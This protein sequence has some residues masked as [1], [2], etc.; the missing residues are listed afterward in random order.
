MWFGTE[1][2]VS[3][4]DSRGVT[5]GDFPHFVNFTTK[6]GLVHNWVYAIHRDPDGV[7]WFGTWGGGVS[8]YDGKGFINFTTK[9]GLANNFVNNIYRDPDGVMWFGTGSFF[10]EEKGGVSRYDERTFVGFTTM[11]GLASNSVLATYSDSDGVIWF[12]TGNGISHY[13]G[14]A[15]VD[16][17]V[18]DEVEDKTIRDMYRDPDG[19]MW[20]ATYG[21]GAF[22]YDG[23]KSAN[24]TTEDGLASNHI[25]DI[26]RDPDGVMWFGTSSGVSRYD[27]EQFVNLTTKDGLAHDHVYAIHGDLDG[28]I[29]FATDGGLSCYDGKEFV[30]FSTEH[31]L[32]H[33]PVRF[34]HRDHDG[35]MWFAVWD[36]I[37]RYDGKE[38]TKFTTRDGLA[39]NLATAMY[40]DSH[41]RMW[42]G[43]MG[44]VSWYDGIAW[45]SLDT[46]DGLV[47]DVLTSVHQDSDGALWFASGKGI[48]RYRRS[49]MPPR[50]H[51]VSVTADRTYHDLSSVPALGIGSR[52]TIEYSAIDLKTLPEKRQYRYRIREGNASRVMH[53]GNMDSGWLKPTRAT[54]LDYIF[55][56]P[57]IYTFD[58]QSI[59]RD[60]NY[61]EP[62]SL[63][64]TVV[65]PFYLRTVFLVPTIGFGATVL[66]TLAFLATALTK[67]RRQVHSYQQAAVRELQDA[68]E[69]QMSLLPETA[70]PVEGMEIAGRSITANTVG[71]D[72][73]DYLALPDDRIGIAIADVSG[74]GL[75]AA[76][77]AVLADGMMHEVA[78]IEASCGRI[79]SRLNAHLYP[80]MEKQMFTAFSFAILD[81]DAG[82]IQWSNAAQPLPLVKR[83]NGASEAEEDG[84]LPLG[85]AP[86]VKY[87]DCELRLQTGDIV[88]F[89]TDGI[90]EAENNVEEMYGTE[91]LMNLVAGIDSTVSAEDVIEA[92]LQD[93]SD[94]VGAAQQYDDMTVV[95]VKKL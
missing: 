90:I 70:P 18:N 76:M 25:W 89:Y 52:V 47:G 24:L 3:R 41:G 68:R 32:E 62:A 45:A 82:V 71:G 14:N 94:F 85:M 16:S 79:L 87:P 8:R 12:A 26:Y 64:L 60:L 50:V 28:T 2:G 86:D 30:T 38:F 5:I 7:M 43:T 69:M 9:D 84:Q 46:R 88:I 29:W 75:R 15:F 17:T 57:G 22:R 49:T 53:K 56:K 48:T 34:I 83:S 23:K 6:D 33:K 59:D 35:A 92:I 55:D 81:E 63:E 77:N 19:V 11:D 65:T 95:A 20:F 39:N 54:S 72:F 91:R 4:Y 93:V 80:L 42:F 61:S 44:G 51:I 10:V 21:S 66:A 74:K 13:D 67:R 40:T 1:G 78:I 73:F 37:Y 27:G 58:V 36:G 31:G